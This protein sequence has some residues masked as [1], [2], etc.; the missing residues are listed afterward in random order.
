MHKPCRHVANAS[1]LLA[2]FLLSAGL[3]QANSPP[4]RAPFSNAGDFSEAAILSGV[5]AKR[6]QC[7]AADNTV[8]AETKNSG[9]ECLKY[10]KGGFGAARSGQPV[11]AMVYFHGDVF[12]GVGKTGKSYL[13]LNNTT[14]QNQADSWAKYVGVPYIF[15]GRPG[16]H[17]SSG[18]HMQRRRIAE[19][20]LISAAL[21]ALKKRHNINEWVV[22][23]QSGGG[24]VTSALIT[25]RADIVCAVPTSAVSSP[26]IR[27][28]K[29]GLS[30][31]TT[32]YS[33]SYEPSKF[34]VKDK[35]NPKLRV[36]VLGDPKDKNVPWPAQTVMA[37]A[38]KTAQI[39]VQVLKGE[40]AGPESHGLV[41]SA[42]I[43]AGWCARDLST[44]E[45]LLR[46][47]K[48]LK[49]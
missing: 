2:I 47:G 12:V 41:Q 1:A 32:G 3:A 13:E 27:W 35:T 7:E 34:I 37:D 40:G 28:G 48:G 21:D 31:D 43:V 44:D 4:G 23:G 15:V 38:L 24:H 14:L 39:P 49:G 17:G 6:A 22:T 26:R 25:G 36:F 5:S 46:A 8:W 33:D 30:K 16:T 45:I 20:E 19:S 18:D 42:R 29:K 10:W 11:R 9:T